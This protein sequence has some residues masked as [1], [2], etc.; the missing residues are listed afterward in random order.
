MKDITHNDWCEEVLSIR[1][2]LSPLDPD[3][4][5]LYNRFRMMIYSPVF[6]DFICLDADAP[7]PNLLAWLHAAKLYTAVNMLKALEGDWENGVGN[8]LDEVDFGKR[9]VKSSRFLIVN[10]ISKAIMHLPLQ[11]VGSL[12]NRRDCPTAVYEMVLKRTPALTYEE[13][14]TH[15][16]F[17]CEVV[18]FTFHY[19]EN[20]YFQRKPTLCERLA[21]GVLLQE[22]RIKNYADE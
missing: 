2:G 20:A 12:M 22:N 3:L 15:N 21:M 13:Y 6:E 17:I 16:S 1:S 19:I 14:G 5:V 8:L 9:A 4:Q 11:A 10:L 7:L 18:A